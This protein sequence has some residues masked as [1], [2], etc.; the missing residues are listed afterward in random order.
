MLAVEQVSSRCH[1]GTGH[2]C[3]LLT[4]GMS[5]ATVLLLMVVFAKL[6]GVSPPSYW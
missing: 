4:A 5:S 2:P 3:Q 6:Y 1:V